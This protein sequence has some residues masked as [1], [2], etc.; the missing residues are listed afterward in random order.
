MNVMNRKMFANRDA[1]RKLANMGGIIASS[2]ELLGTAQRF[3][4]GGTVPTRRSDIKSFEQF[5]P[6]LRSRGPNTAGEAYI[7]NNVRNAQFS[8]ELEKVRDLIRF[9]SKTDPD[10]AKLLEEKYAPYLNRKAD[11]LDALFKIRSGNEIDDSGIQALLPQM[12]SPASNFSVVS[13]QDPTQNYPTYSRQSDTDPLAS[14][15]QNDLTEFEKI[16]QGMD[17]VPEA[18][19]SVEPAVVKVKTVR[20][21]DPLGGTDYEL[22]SD[23]SAILVSSGTKIDPNNASNQTF[24]QM[25]QDLPD[26]SDTSDMSDMSQPPVIE[27]PKLDSAPITEDERGVLSRIGSSITDFV[28]ADLAQGFPKLPD[29]REAKEELIRGEG[30]FSSQ[31][32]V[33]PEVQMDDGPA[34]TYDQIVS[35]A[36]SGEPI[37]TSDLVKSVEAGLLNDTQSADVNSM[38]DGD[39]IPNEQDQSIAN[40]EGGSEFVNKPANPDM[41]PSKVYD[42]ASDYFAGIFN[43][44][45]NK[46][47]QEVE[48]ERAEETK[49]Y[50]DEV[51][52]TAEKKELAEFEQI[53]DSM[54]A[55]PKAGTKEEADSNKV[56]A[57]LNNAVKNE[58]KKDDGGSPANAGANIFLDAAGVDSSNMTLKDKVTSM[59]EIYTD[60]LGYDDEDESELFWLNMA[61]V[62]FLV[63]SGQDPNALANIATGF[64]QGATKFAEDKRDKKARDDKMTLAA[65]GE[66]MADERA[67]TKF[68]R[69]LALVK[70][71]G[72]AKDADDRSNYLYKSTFDNT[73]TDFLEND[74]G[75]YAGAIDAARNAASAA[76][77]GAGLASTIVSQAQTNSIQDEIDKQLRLKVPVETIRNQ[78]KQANRDPDSFRFA[79]S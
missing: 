43:S 37:T 25:L 53:R 8:R 2:P 24:L 51:G 10:Y 47:Q 19:Q 72:E 59:K 42:L 38:I 18:G 63:A 77:P 64:A 40:L 41:L 1:R 26:V 28:K 73:Y 14:T 56:I 75:N 54:D 9:Y 45:T 69:D 79:L 11:E 34:L 35:K 6:L 23:G 78:L 5:R 7:I 30:I 76:A 16:R 31:P 27:E 62:G 32:V 60:L 29:S 61:Q 21:G 49:Q 68:G 48:K 39:Y 17:A 74:P 20:V 44:R 12:D 71:R 67:T 36:N 33:Q 52:I 50:E 66:V 46:E 15:T 65:F 13:P 55:M 4:E 58:T 70:A 22:Y 57:D 3:E